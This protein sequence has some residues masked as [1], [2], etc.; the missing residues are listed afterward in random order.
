MLGRT[1]VFALICSSFIRPVIGP[2]NSTTYRDDSVHYSFSYPGDFKNRSVSS[3]RP[4]GD[5]PSH[6]TELS[7]RITDCLAIPVAAVRPTDGRLFDMVMIMD[8]DLKC[9]NEALSTNGL[10]LFAKGIASKVLAQHGTAEIGQVRTFKL[11]GHEA[12]YLTESV[13]ES[14]KNVGQSLRGGL[15]CALVENHA[16]CW[17]MLS[18]RPET[19]KVLLAL[20]VS[21]DGQPAE[22]LLPPK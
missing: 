5:S 7:E 13:D 15:V 2:D 21:F 4:A 11:A 19:L 22:S 16:V 8:V 17:Q 12:V 3:R 10:V 1:F 9:A 14:A 20:P 18:Y 6:A